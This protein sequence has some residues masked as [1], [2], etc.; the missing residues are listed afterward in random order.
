MA[1]RK[2]RN[3]IGLIVPSVSNDYCNTLIEMLNSEFRKKDF[4]L[5]LAVSDGDIEQERYLLS[6]FWK[7]TDAILIMSDAADYSLLADVVPG[8]IPVVFLNRKPEGCSHTC[9]IEND[10]SAVYREIFSL[11]SAGHSKIGCICNHVHYSTTKEISKAYKDVIALSQ[12]DT[13]EHIYYTHGD[14]TLIPSIVDKLYSLGCTAIF[15]GSQSI[16]SALLKHMYTF[17]KNIDTPIVYAGFANRDTASIT[18][19]LIDVIEQPLTE[20]VSLATQQL[21]YR[22]NHPH[23]PS[24]DFIL[25]STLHKQTRMS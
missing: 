10:Y 18:E 20:T 7:L 25:K 13:E 11:Q 24:R 19:Q 6:Y 8:N 17:N 21:I 16:T 3:T 9:I 12:A 14:I 22:I 15:A 23:T 2:L 5:I 1:P 4:N